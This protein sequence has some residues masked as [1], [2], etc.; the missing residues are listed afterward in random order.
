MK[1][2]LITAEDYKR[3]AKGLPEKARQTMIKE[4]LAIYGWYV[5][6]IHQSLGSVRG[7]PDLQAI[8]N[9]VTVYIE[10][11]TDKGEQ[12]ENQIKIQE[13]LERAGG[14]YVLA[15]HIGDVKFM[16]NNELV[17]SD[18]AVAIDVL[19]NKKMRLAKK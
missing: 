16:A 4:Y 1:K 19:K 3:M 12:G 7:W 17:F 10:V 5:A 11:K 9:G 15:R 8:K 18:G 6:K 13:E 2:D 14:L